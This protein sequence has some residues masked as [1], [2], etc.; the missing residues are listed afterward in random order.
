MRDILHL[1]PLTDGITTQN[2]YNHQSYQCGRCMQG[3]IPVRS[4]MLRQVSLGNGQ[5]L[6]CVDKF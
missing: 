5:S 6:E 4:E 2:E 1:L 3:G